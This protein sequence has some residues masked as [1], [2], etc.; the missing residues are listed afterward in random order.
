[1]VARERDDLTGS[2]RLP[3]PDLDFVPLDLWN[4]S[5]EFDDAQRALALSAS[6]SFP[7]SSAGLLLLATWE[8]D[9]MTTFALAIDP[10]VL[11]LAEWIDGVAQTPLGELEFDVLACGD[12]DLGPVPPGGPGVAPGLGERSRSGRSGWREA[13]RHHGA[14]AAVGW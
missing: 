3:L 14:P 13:P 4:V 9:G 8:D 5:L 2:D 1:M 12:L 7:H 10:A 6:A 11:N